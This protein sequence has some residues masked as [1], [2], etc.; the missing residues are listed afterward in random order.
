MF[1]QPLKLILNADELFSN[2]NTSP[3][4]KLNSAFLIC[5]SGKDHPLF[6]E[7]ERA[8]HKDH[9]DQSLNDLSE[10]Y[11]KRLTDIENEI[12]GAEQAHSSFR[13][14]LSDLE[15]YLKGSPSTAD[16]VFYDKFWQV[17]FPEGVDVFSNP[18]IHAEKLR[19][20]RLVKITQTNRN[21]VS[22]PGRELIFTSNV[23]LGIPNKN[24]DIESLHYDSDLKEELKKAM[25]EQQLFW[26]DHPV[27]IGVKPEANEI[28]YGLTGLD[29]SMEEEKK[30]GN[31]KEEK[32]ICILSVSVTHKGLQGIARQYIARELQHHGG[33]KNLDVYVF[34]EQDTRQL[35]D[36]FFMELL[37]TD[38]HENEA[39]NMLGVFGVDG[40]YGRHYSFLKAIAA[41][42][43]VVINQKIRATFKIDLDQVFAQK[44]LIEQTGSSALEHFKTPLWG[45][46]GI[47]SHNEELE[48]GMIA[49]ALV[50]E[51]DIH[52]G[53]YTP[54][55]PF[56]EEV[57]KGEELIFFSKMLMALSTRGELMTRYRENS[58][59][60]GKTTCIERIHVTGGTNGILIDFLRK[61][62]PF[63]PTFIGRAEDQCYL[64]SALGHG[65][66]TRL[67]YLHKDGLI[68]R[69]DKEA[70]AR[71]A[72]KAAR[73]GNIAGDY[74]RTLYF[75]EYAGYISNNVARLKEKVDPFTGC[76]IS[77]IPI[78]ICLL[79]YAIQGNR[80]FDRGEDQPGRRF[81]FENS[82]RLEK[83]IN[84]TA[85]DPSD[86]R[87]QAERERKGW[88]LFYDVLEKIELL[89][90]KQDPEGLK[91]T[92]K[93]REII[94]NCRIEL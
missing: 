57:P 62:R 29:R 94:G 52:K 63:T 92:A 82:N 61:Y 30:R 66:K 80:F 16:K 65:K 22:E 13:E 3:A 73:F 51:K 12:S 84:F 9:T 47:G 1:C 77:T 6:H 68:M 42:W 39:R 79:R 26:F 27:Q 88:N 7:A 43:S 35:L 49:G 81:L 4:N 86:L 2:E 37:D 5:L 71:E 64:L 58:D 75:S 25:S 28:L 44:E 41:L 23:L 34:T 70:F 69:H 31:L 55:V 85:G 91:L 59:I 87:I 48:L 56:P 38:I 19:A 90:K 33:L 67:A 89:N 24:T 15:T 45:A 18:H 50:N 11:C 60:N 21:P 17:F 78:T 8:L 14:A 76:F 46:T 74:I 32:V 53:L 83:A 10:F 40:E 20:S 72:I 93:A 54:D 36:E